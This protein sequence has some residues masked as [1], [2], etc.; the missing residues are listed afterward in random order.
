M[1]QWTSLSSM[2][3]CK[4]ALGL[5]AGARGGALQHAAHWWTP[6]AGACQQGSR[7]RWEGVRWMDG[8][9]A[10]MMHACMDAWVDGWMKRWPQAA[11]PRLGRLRCRPPVHRHV[12]FAMRA[13]QHP[14]VRSCRATS[15]AAQDKDASKQPILGC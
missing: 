6:A 4:H 13:A 11:A 1:R 7:C 2:G 10:R 12:H 3:G 14:S 8:A 15:M 9:R 5:G